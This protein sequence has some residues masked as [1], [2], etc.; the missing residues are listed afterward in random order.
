MKRH[1]L[2]RK[3]TTLALGCWISLHFSLLLRIPQIFHW[4]WYAVTADLI[5]TQALLRR[6]GEADFQRLP[7]FFILAFLS[8]V[9][10][11]VVVT[12]LFTHLQTNQFFS[13]KQ[14]G[15]RPKYYAEI[16]TCYFTNSIK[17]FFGGSFV[18]V[19]YTRT[20][21]GLVILDL[22]NA[23]D[24]ANHDIPKCAV[25]DGWTRKKIS[26]T[27]EKQNG[28]SPRTATCS[29]ALHSVYQWFACK[30]PRGWW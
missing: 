27:I 29:N 9:L 18:G 11:N 19:E 1:T 24:T 4:H 26:E 2:H 10:E 30:L 5:L 13:L 8:W 16:A 3:R 6:P 20:F 12:Q 14:F 15:F 21:E 17:G 28:H 22:K 7:N 25:C 23:F